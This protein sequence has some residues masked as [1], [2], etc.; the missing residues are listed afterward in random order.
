M[1][2][3]V[4]T[5]MG[6]I[7]PIG[8]SIDAVLDSLNT[9][10]SG[11]KKMESWNKINGLRVN[12]AGSCQGYDEKRVSRKD[13]RTMGR[14][15]V[16]AS[17][18]TMDA[19][20]QAGIENDI[21]ASPDTGIAMGSTTGSG[22]IIE[23]IFTDYSETGGITR[24]EGTSFMKIMNHTISANVSSMLKTKGRVISP[25]CACATS[26]QSIGEG[27]EII[28]NG[29][30]KVMLCGGADDLHP[31]TGG[32]FDVL[33][34]ASKKY[35]DSPSQTPRPF[36][37]DRDGLVVSEGAGT[38]LLEDYEH[39]IG[40]G[41]EILGEIVGYSTCCDGNHM[42]SP[43]T[44]G[45]V[46][47]MSQALASAKCDIS[48]I[49]YINAHAT[50]TEQ[51]DIAESEAIKQLAGN[52]IPVSGTKGYT[53]HTLAASGVME[54][55]FCLLMMKHSFVAP[56]LN[57]EN[58]DPRC[59][60]IQHVKEKIEKDINMVMTNNFAFGGINASLILKKYQ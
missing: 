40:R 8:N 51:G 4:I 50:A 19:I 18:A 10:Y 11:I 39:A 48:E 43:G 49:D 58:I 41:A 36:D 7:S 29:Y 28:K 25:C 31:S 33:H 22:E 16:M 5:G 53:G 45:M 15:A 2:R 20:D 21:I 24:L 34:A 44:D 37:K 52:S 23:K 47:C 35:C 56:T 26:T 1:K 60:G 12:I 46:R 59:D 9:N 6:I 13:R 30:Q 27:Y 32:V 55:I 38:L 3:V 14:M 57:L 42:T 17:I 54:A